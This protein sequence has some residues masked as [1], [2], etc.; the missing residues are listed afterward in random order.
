MINSI[1][2]PCHL[3]SP[4]PHNTNMTRIQPG[5]V[6]IL[7]QG[8]HAGTKAVVVH[9]YDEGTPSHRRPHALVAGAD[10]TVSARR[11]P[12]ML[13]GG[14]RK[15]QSRSTLAPFLHTVDYNHMMTTSIV[16][17]GATHKE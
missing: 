4:I 9:A 1:L 2:I 6:C 5:T 16:L 11:G 3:S 8:K 10:V 14:P 7:L 12:R 17:Q 13:F 15:G